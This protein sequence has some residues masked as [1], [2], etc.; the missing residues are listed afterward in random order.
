MPVNAELSQTQLL[1]DRLSVP[2]SRIVI[3][4]LSSAMED[5]DFGA[6]GRLC[7]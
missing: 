3:G 6:R 5:D 1:E 4:T 2:R 7:L